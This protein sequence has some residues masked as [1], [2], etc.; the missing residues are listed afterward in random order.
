L[1]L[2]CGAALLVRAAKQL[3]AEVKA[4][5]QSRLTET[6]VRVNAPP[7]AS[8]SVADVSSNLVARTRGL[9]DVADAAVIAEQA[10]TDRVVTVTDPGGALRAVN[11]PR[12]GRT[13]VSPSYLRTMGFEIAHGR[14]FLEAEAS[15]SVIVDPQFARSLWPGADAVGRMVKFGA[16][17]TAGRW[18]TVVGVR[19]PVGLESQDASKPGIGQAYAL[20]VPEDHLAGGKTPT[21]NPEIELVV[22]ASRNAH[23]TP[24]VLSASFAG[25]TRTSPTYIGTFDEWTGA[26]G[27][28]ENQNF[29]GVLFSLFAV[30]ALALA[31]LGVYGIVSHS[32][33]ERR[34]EIGVRIALGSSAREILYVVLRE[35]NVF[36]LAG[37]ALG[38]WL[39][40]D[41]AWLVREFL[42]FA[43][44]DVYSIE[45]YV[46]AAAFLFAVAVVAAFIPAHRATKIDPV[47]A[48]RCE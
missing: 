27:R 29:V 17:N 40:R 12:W 38:L 8:W 3:D 18:F 30:I 43:E 37:T 35:G 2:V 39:I 22:R 32:V 5:D 13:I 14:D 42:R 19:K 46:P 28:R 9:I 41:M 34:R 44:A 25:D 48:L 7:G 1:A 36:L 16:P 10:D 11:A 33:A 15:P 45:L 24:I 6:R 4:W 31:A 26:A 21:A 20:A 47:E 23:R